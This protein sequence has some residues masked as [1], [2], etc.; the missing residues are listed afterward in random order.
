MNA[1]RRLQTAADFMPP[2]ADV[3]NLRE[4]SVV[5]LASRGILDADQVAAAWRFERAWKVVSAFRPVA[6]EIGT[7]KIRGSHTER[8]LLAAMEL[9]LCRRL[10]GVYGFK[11]VA[12]VCGNGYA[13]PDLFPKRRDRDTATDMLRVHLTELSELWR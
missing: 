2:V 6:V 8:Q 11:L 13:I 10:L 3:A 4:S 1:A 7:M 5:V 9:R 12:A